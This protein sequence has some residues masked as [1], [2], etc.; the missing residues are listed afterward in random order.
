LT[1]RSMTKAA[2]QIG[3]CW[4]GSCGGGHACM[5]CLSCHRACTGGAQCQRRWQRQPISGNPRAAAATQNM[6]DRPRAAVQHAMHAH[7]RLA[8]GGE[9]LTESLS[10][11]VRSTTRAECRTQRCGRHSCRGG[12]RALVRFLSNDCKL[13]P[14]SARTTG[15]SAW[16]DAL[17]LL[18]Q[19]CKALGMRLGHSFP[20][21]SGALCSTSYT[22]A[23]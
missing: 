21:C 2:S 14:C 18:Q 12:G 6:V 23:A 4:R 11:S 16:L 17:G 1:V 8:C 7:V 20:A 9:L 22:P 3:R 15:S 5:C 10:Q 19:R 13:P